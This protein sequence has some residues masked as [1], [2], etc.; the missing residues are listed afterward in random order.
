MEAYFIR[1]LSNSKMVDAY[2]GLDGKARAAELVSIHNKLYS[3]DMWFVS[4]E[5][6]N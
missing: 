2:E 1:K 5:K 6:V 4:E 3:N